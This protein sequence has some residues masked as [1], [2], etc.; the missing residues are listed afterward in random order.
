MKTLTQFLKE[1]LQSHTFHVHK[2]GKKVHTLTIDS[3]DDVTA[4]HV[5][6]RLVSRGDFGPEITVV[7]HI[8]KPVTQQVHRKSS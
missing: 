7:K 8:K 1:E 2:D 6:K 5:K 4:D 3:D